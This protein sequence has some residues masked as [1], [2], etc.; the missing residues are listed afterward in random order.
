MQKEYPAAV[1]LSGLRHLALR[2]TDM[3]RARGFY[4]GLLGMN[5]VWEPDPENVYLSSGWDNLALHQVPKEELPAFE[6]GPN[7]PLDHFGFIVSSPEEV[8]AYHHKMAEA[9][10]RIVKPLKRHRDGSHSFYMADPDGN[11]IQILYEPNIS[12][13]APPLTSPPET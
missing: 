4:E 11:V 13:L 6:N 8:E 7:Q 5:V 3:A 10:V 2:V 12:P 9:G 1:R